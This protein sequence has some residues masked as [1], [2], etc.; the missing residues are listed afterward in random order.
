[1]W[2][3]FQQFVNKAETEHDFGFFFADAT[4]LH[5]EHGFL[6]QLS[7]GSAMGTFHVVGIDFQFWLGINLGGVGQQQVFI[8]QLRQCFLRLRMNMNPAIKNGASGV[9]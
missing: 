3:G 5:I 4:A 8:A 1:M 2:Q 9:C 7:N 6:F